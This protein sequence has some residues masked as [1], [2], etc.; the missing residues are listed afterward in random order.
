MIFPSSDVLFSKDSRKFEKMEGK[1][2]RLL[3][4][5]PILNGIKGQGEIT[6]VFY[7]NGRKPLCFVPK[8]GN[9]YLLC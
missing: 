5:I 1:P 6:F 8:G 4:I 9:F 3:N 7:V 2:F